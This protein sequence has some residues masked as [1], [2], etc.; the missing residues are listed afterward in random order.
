MGADSLAGFADWKR[1]EDILALARIGVV[2]RTAQDL[3]G[4][5]DT[6]PAGWRRRVDTMQ[7][8]L[9][10]LSSTD[11]RRR[12]LAGQDISGLVPDSVIQLIQERRLYL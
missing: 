10:E 6:F 2:S 9:L 3:S 1:P 12:V 5:L 11:I 7:M 8:P 4:I